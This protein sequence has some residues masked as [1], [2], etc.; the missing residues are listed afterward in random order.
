[1]SNRPLRI[2]S[3]GAHMAYTAI[4]QRIRLLIPAKLDDNYD[5]VAAPLRREI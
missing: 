1:M 2:L 3:P 4:L 5:A